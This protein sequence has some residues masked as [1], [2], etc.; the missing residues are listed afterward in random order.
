MI[1]S[2][3]DMRKGKIVNTSEHRSALHTSLR[4]PSSTIPHARKVHE[5][6]D[7]FCKFADDVRN[8][9]RRGCA[10]DRITDVIN[11]GIGG[12][13]MGPRTVY[14]ALRTTKPEINLHFLAAADRV[15]FDRITSSLDPFKTLVAISS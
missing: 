3:N 12:S 13:D 4:D 6:L 2:L 7:R 5:T 15:T 1:E 11:I 14:N 8:W 10:G 9:K